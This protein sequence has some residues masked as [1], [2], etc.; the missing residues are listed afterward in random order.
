MS[1]TKDLGMDASKTYDAC[2][3]DCILYYG[4]GKESLDECPECGE[5]RYHISTSSKKVGRKV[6]RHI[7][8]APQFERLFGCK[9]MSQLMDYHVRGRSTDGVM[10]MPAD[11]VAWRKIEEKWPI[12]KDEPRNA[13]I[14]LALDGVNPY[15]NQST[16]WSTC[17]VIAINNNLPPW[18]STRKEHAML[19]LIIPGYTLWKFLILSLHGNSNKFHGANDKLK[20]MS[21]QVQ[22]NRNIW[23]HTWSL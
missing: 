3:N 13:R 10:R 17:P 9:E 20:L 15:G 1:L 14:S 21:L 19:T 8:L 11:G 16:Q 12:F 2:P 23:T 18:L 5:K 4:D 22:I 7:P 6:L